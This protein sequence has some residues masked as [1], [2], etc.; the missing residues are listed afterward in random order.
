MKAMRRL[1]L[2]A[3]HSARLEARLTRYSFVRRAVRRF[4]PGEDLDAALAEAE[5]LGR[6][7]VPTVLTLL[8]ENARDEREVEAVVAEFRRA[9]DEGLRRK[10]DAQIS[11]K[12]THLGLDLDPDLAHRS[13]DRLATRAAETG[14]FVWIDIEG[15][16]YTDLTLE[17]YR[18]VRRLH[19]NVGVCLQAYLRRTAADLE[20]LLSCGPAIRLVKGAYSEPPELAFPAKRDVDSNYLCLAIRVLETLGTRPA[21]PPR[22]AFG[23][24]DRRLIER[25]RQ[26]ADH[27]GIDRS[28]YEFEMLY[29][30][31]TR[32]GMRLAEAGYRYRVLISYGS[33]WFP[34]YMRRLA[35]RPAN[36][37]FV[38][39]SAFAR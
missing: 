27:R 23:T 39:R 5:R 36:V 22:V 14:S 4:M 15:S 10:L 21:A 20:D 32:E 38:V 8:G 19:E 1:F 16:R 37:W 17:Q 11:V 12:L 28:A 13:L 2:R 7:G 25:I 29:G 9:L 6:A 33:A 18:R 26:A 3:S 31:G 24:H 30:I 34:W 35:E